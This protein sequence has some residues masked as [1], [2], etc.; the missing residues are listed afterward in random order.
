MKLSNIIDKLWNADAERGVIWGF[1]AGTIVMGLIGHIDPAIDLDSVDSALPYSVVWSWLSPQ[2]WNPQPYL[3]ILMLMSL[4]IYAVEWKLVKMGKIPKWLF[5]MNLAVNTLWMAWSTPQY[6]LQTIFSPLAAINPIVF[7]LEILFKLP[8]GWSWNL[9]DAH[10]ACGIF[11]K[12]SYYVGGRFT[13]V[14]PSNWAHYFQGL[15]WVIPVIVWFKKRRQK[16][17]S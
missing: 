6:V 12:C 11:G 16:N 15:M 7:P 3:M 13:G 10:V 5:I 8:L 4:A 2:Y 14:D 1:I 17:E 9:Q